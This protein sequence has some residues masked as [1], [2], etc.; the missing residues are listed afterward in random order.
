[1]SDAIGSPI[2]VS[3]LAGYASGRRW[4]KRTTS[5][6]F[7]RPVR[8]VNAST[9]SALVAA[10]SGPGGWVG[11]RFGWVVLGFRGLE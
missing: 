8:S 1:M 3:L 5:R 9:Y 6:R 7:L 11:I 4:G 2:T 10:S